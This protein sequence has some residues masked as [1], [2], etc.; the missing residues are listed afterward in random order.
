MPIGGGY[1]RL[2]PYNA[3]RRAIGRFARREEH[4]GHAGTQQRPTFR[5][6]V[7]VTASGP[8]GLAGGQVLVGHAVIPPSIQRTLLLRLAV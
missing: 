4:L 8:G 2:L 7:A 1:F 3:T 6:H 5:L